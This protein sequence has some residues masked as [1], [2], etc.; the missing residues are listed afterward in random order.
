MSTKRRHCSVFVIA[1]IILALSL[2]SSVTTAAQ[3]QDDPA[4]ITTTK[5]KI[6]DPIKK[7]YDK[8]PPKGKFATGAFVGLTSS[9][10]VIKSAVK[11]AKIAGTA[12]VVAE[13]LNYTGMLNI[14]ELLREN[15]SLVSKAQ[16]MVKSNVNRMRVQIRHHLNPTNVKAFVE[17]AVEVDRMGSIG[18]ATGVATGVL[19]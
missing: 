4:W 5:E 7:K 15:T 18:F 14:D 3:Q 16:K 10:F 6:L 1:A 2:L 9:H 19:I 8:L 17:H 11:S 12:F 13:V